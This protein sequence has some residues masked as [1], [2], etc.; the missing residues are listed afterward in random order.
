MDSRVLGGVSSA[1]SSSSREHAGEGVFST[2]FPGEKSAKVGPHS[3]L[4]VP[5]SVSPSTSSAHL[6]GSSLMRMTMC[7]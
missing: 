6:E 4:R 3:S 7:G 1:C 5:A 2:S